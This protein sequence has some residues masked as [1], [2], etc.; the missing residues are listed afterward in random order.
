[1]H[2]DDE[3]LARDLPRLMGRRGV[4]L[5][6]LGLGLGGYALAQAL[7]P[8]DSEAN[9]FGTGADGGQC[10]KT[11]AETNG[12][13]PADGSNS[14][15][16]QVVD[17]LK[18]QSVMRDDI[19]T[20][21]GDLD[22]AAEG[23]PLELEIALISVDGCKPLGGHAI[24]LWHADAEGRYSLYDLPE[25]NYLRGVVLTD[26]SGVARVTTIVPGCYDGRWPHIHFEVF[27]S[28]E[29]AVAGGALLTSQMA[30]PEATC[31]EAYADARYP[32][33]LRN[34]DRTSLDGDNVF[35]DNTPEQVAQ[36]LLT[37]TR[38]ATGYA[39]KVTVGL[40]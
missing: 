30:L 3:G 33:S 18:Q 38:T 40:G 21:F 14:R 8:S 29:A 16:G 13:Y 17:V 32:A 12:P 28:A 22:G 24:Y 10:L 6:L 23:I 25:R 5:S 27:A 19:R 34:L 4:V 9:V 39:A 15:E 7:P 36:Q 2:D 20:S 35:G 26:A 31:R 11:P 1:M 37:M